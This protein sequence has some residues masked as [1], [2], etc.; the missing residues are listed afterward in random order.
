MIKKVNFGIGV[1]IE[2]VERFKELNLLN[3][4]SFLKKIF[5]DHE[6]KYCFSK[7]FPAQH[8]AGRYAAKEAIVKALCTIRKLQ[9]NYNEIEICSIKKIPIVK[10]NRKSLQNILFFISI[11]HTEDTAIAFATVMD[12]KI[13]T[14]YA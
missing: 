9:I 6:L 10:T 3:N 8:L 13:F 11:S 5:T 7:K 12:K 4:G 14:I 1:D 2:K